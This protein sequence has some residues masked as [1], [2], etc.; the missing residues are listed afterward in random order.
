MKKNKEWMKK[1]KMR[2]IEIEC[3]TKLDKSQIYFKFEYEKRRKNEND[4]WIVWRIMK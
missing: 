3:T 1:V 2:K 4:E